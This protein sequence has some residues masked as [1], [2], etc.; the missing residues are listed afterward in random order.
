MDALPDLLHREHNDSDFCDFFVNSLPFFPRPAN[1]SGKERR[2]ADISCA[3]AGINAAERG[4][5][6]GVNKKR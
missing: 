1:S 4:I 3:A 2:L 5:R 6:T